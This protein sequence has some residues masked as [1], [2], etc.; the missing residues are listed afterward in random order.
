MSFYSLLIRGGASRKQLRRIIDFTTTQLQCPVVSYI[1]PMLQLLEGDLD[2]RCVEE[3]LQLIQK[4]MESQ[5]PGA[6]RSFVVFSHSNNGSFVYGAIKSRI[7]DPLSE[8]HSLEG[9]LRGVIFDS[10]PAL[11]ESPSAGAA[12]KSSFLSHLYLGL[13][14]A[15]SFSFPSVAIVTGRPVYVHAFWTPAITI[16]AIVWKLLHPTE[17]EKKAGRP[18]FDARSRL[19]NQ[20][21]RNVPT[22]PHLFLFSSGDK[23][24]RVQWVKDYTEFLHKEHPGLKITEHDFVTTGHV[25]HLLRQPKVYAEEL[26]KFFETLDLD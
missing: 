26:R 22:V 5:E 11:F 24:L 13:K 1:N 14:S 21:K 10:A 15:F 4:Q 7:Q 16:W 2:S 3:I 12:S 18:I 17:Q 25:Q 8:Y 6:P 23:L 9:R 19:R 20:L